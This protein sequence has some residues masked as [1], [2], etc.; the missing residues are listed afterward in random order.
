MFANERFDEIIDIL[1]EHKHIDV[2]TLSKMLYVS[3]ATIRR[4]LNEMKDL[5]LIVRS[6]GGAILPENI[7]EVSI[8]VRMNEN[9]SDKEHTA[10][11]ALPLIPEFR[12]VFIDSSSTALALATRMDLSFKTVVTNNLQTAITLSKK[13][14][15]NLISLGGNIH[16]NTISSTGSFTIRQLED[17]TFDLIILSCTAVNGKEILENSLEQKELKLA[18][19]KR[20]KTKMLLFDHNKY[21]AHATYRLCSLSDFDIVV[22]D[23]D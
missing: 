21:T 19:L 22:T 5:G 1:K 10:S 13:P 8:F 12:S 9:A 23:I 14:N 7:D 11:N 16:Y 4:D 6:H 17:F 3:E 2:K 18:A 20:S 15:I